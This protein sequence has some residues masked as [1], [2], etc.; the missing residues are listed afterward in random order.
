MR[1]VSECQ[2]KQGAAALHPYHLNPS[3]PPSHLAS[4]TGGAK[5]T[6]C[7]SVLHTTHLLV[8]DIVV[9][10]FPVPYARRQAV[11]LRSSLHRP[12]LL[13]GLN[14]VSLLVLI[15]VRPR[16]DVVVVRAAVLFLGRLSEEALLFDHAL[17]V[18]LQEPVI[19]RTG[20]DRADP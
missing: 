18:L 20:D 12:E 10:P 4:T 9:V 15:V 1:A 2:P 8:D 19:G 5:Q 17:F 13:P 3:A 14:E 11:L 16:D 6:V 7:T